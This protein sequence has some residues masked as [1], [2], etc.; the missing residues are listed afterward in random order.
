M[1]MV[2]EGDDRRPLEGGGG[3]DSFKRERPRHVMICVSSIVLTKAFR[4]IRSEQC[5][6]I[7]PVSRP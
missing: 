7:R 1:Y 4:Y 2:S 6:F 3:H 5:P